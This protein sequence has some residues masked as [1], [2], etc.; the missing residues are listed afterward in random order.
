[1]FSSHV[2]N[3]LS[4]EG[5]IVFVATTRFPFRLIFQFDVMADSNSDV[6]NTAKLPLHAIP[7]D[8]DDILPAFW[9]IL[10]FAVIVVVVRPP[11][12]VPDDDDVKAPDRVVVD[13][14][15]NT[16]PIAQFPA[17]EKFM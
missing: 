9:V 5:E 14:T 16:P 2:S 10:L 13:A 11:P 15:V 4:S 3:I 7:P 12:N 8:P 6:P 17:E 1:M